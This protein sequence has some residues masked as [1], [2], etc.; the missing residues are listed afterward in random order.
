M[1][2]RARRDIV[3]RVTDYRQAHG[4]FARYSPIPSLVLIAEGDLTY[5][6]LT[7]NGHRSG[8]AALLL[9]DVEPVQGLHLG[10]GGEHK[11]EGGFNQPNSYGGRGYVLWFFAPHAD[12]RIDNFYQR[13]SNALEQRAVL[14]FLAQLHVY[15]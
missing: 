15:L 4:L 9:A 3:Y 1:V 6:S 2:T 7:W 14:T 8:H 11:N 13:V 12:V 5:H 10:L